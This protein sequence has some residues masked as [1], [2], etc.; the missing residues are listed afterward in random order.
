VLNVFGQIAIFWEIKKVSWNSNF[1]LRETNWLKPASSLLPC[2]G[3]KLALKLVMSEI[4]S[5]DLYD[6]SVVP[7]FKSV[8]IVCVVWQRL[9]TQGMHC[10]CYWF[11][12]QWMWT[13]S[14][15]QKH[16][17][18]LNCRNT[19]LSI[20]NTPKKHDVEVNFLL[21]SRSKLCEYIFQN[22]TALSSYIDARIFFPRIQYH[23]FIHSFIQQSVLRQVQS[24]FQSEIST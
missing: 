21:F 1:T 10:C 14:S 3:T 16:H 20:S 17:S 24:L 4:W 19:K 13:N 12:A 6:A 8:P 9:L 18:V 7:S 23:S 15:C 5:W 11:K 22:I 2:N